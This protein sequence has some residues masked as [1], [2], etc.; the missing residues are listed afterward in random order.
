MGASF[1]K[2]LRLKT[3]FMIQ[4][5]FTPTPSS[6]LKVSS[7]TISTII[8]LGLTNSSFLLS[9]PSISR[10]SSPWMHALEVL[11]PIFSSRRNS[12]R[13]WF[14]FVA[15][16]IEKT[17]NF[18]LKQSRWRQRAII[19]DFDSLKGFSRHKRT[20]AKVAFGFCL[21]DKIFPSNSFVLWRISLNFFV[22]HSCYFFL[23][24]HL[25][26]WRYLSFEES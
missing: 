7:F 21:H 23:P 1:R 4:F 8:I 11:W 14:R 18:L 22:P 10:K 17:W 9:S 20:G 24:M 19:W 5:L 15:D 2:H 12:Q 16:Q 6:A 25:P 13:K 26:R 3:H